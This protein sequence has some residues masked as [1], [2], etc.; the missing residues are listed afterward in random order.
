MGA[1][2]PFDCIIAP[3]VDRGVSV[4]FTVT[5]DAYEDRDLS[6]GLVFI[7]SPVWVQGSRQV[8]NLSPEDPHYRRGGVKR[9]LAAERTEV[10]L[11]VVKR[12]TV[13]AHREGH[14][15]PQDMIELVSDLEDEGFSVT[16]LQTASAQR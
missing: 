3:I 5:F 16:L 8:V 14:A 6:Y 12:C 4:R 9:L 1:R 13:V 15:Q 2:R 11:E 7:P 10:D